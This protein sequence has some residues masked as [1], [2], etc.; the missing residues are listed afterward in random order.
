VTKGY[1]VLPYGIHLGLLTTNSP[2]RPE[3]P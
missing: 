3:A 2:T 1:R